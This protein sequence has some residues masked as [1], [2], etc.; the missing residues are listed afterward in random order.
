[1]RQAGSVSAAGSGV[2]VLASQLGTGGAE[3]HTVALA[4]LLGREFTVVL[5]YLKPREDML[6]LVSREAVRDVRCLNAR[7]RLDL[8]ALQEL[9]ALCRENDVKVIVCANAFA[10]FYAQLARALLPD[11]VSVV[12]VF[13]TTKLRTIKEQLELAFYRPFFW[14][15]SHLI[16][17]CDGQ[18]RYW[19]RRFL[20]ARR[21][22]MIYN[23]VDVAHFD[24][25]V[26]TSTTDATRT[27][28]GFASDDRVVG[29]C[30]VLRPEKAH[31]HLLQ[32]VARRAQQGQRWR[33]L[34]IGDGPLRTLI[35]AEAERLGLTGDIRITG[36]QADVRRWLAACDVVAIVSTAIE[37]FSV[38]AL[39]AMA[40]ARPMIM[41]DIG[42]AREQ[43]EPGVNGMLFR[44]GDVDAL[45]GCLRTCWDKNLTQAM[46]AAARIRVQR[47]FSLQSMADR[48][49]SLL[50]RIVS[51]HAKA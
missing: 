36:M 22:H 30:A 47:E 1:M 37:T 45:A 32:A 9:R 48:Y 15:A 6:W 25:R 41:S 3:R 11:P 40:M 5:A 17:V 16:F 38:A 7:S 39:E 50:R 35:E 18:R 2:L 14:F 34:I 31:T 43:V 23:G 33:V 27:E 24:P 20:W 21:T 28:L 51:N 13:H 12:E 49:V 29:I 4:N 8:K 19:Q 44:A 10:L 42:G 46:G 26:F